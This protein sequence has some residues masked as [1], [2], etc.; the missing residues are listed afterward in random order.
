MRWR[1]F[2]IES[3]NNQR[4]NLIENFTKSYHMPRSNIGLSAVLI[5]FTVCMTSLPQLKQI[6]YCCQNKL[7]T[8]VWQ[9][10]LLGTDNFES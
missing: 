5:Y 1:L 7:G 3:R 8:Y 10:P 6:I 4:T 9:R 2:V